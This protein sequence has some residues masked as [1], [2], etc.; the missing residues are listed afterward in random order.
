MNFKNTR[1][2][3]RFKFISFSFCIDISCSCFYFESD[4]KTTT[5]VLKTSVKMG[6]C[7]QQSNEPDIEATISLRSTFE[8][9]IPMKKIYTTL[10][11]AILMV[12]TTKT[13]VS[14]YSFSSQLVTYA[15]ITGGTVFGSSTQDDGAF[16]NP[17]TPGSTGATGPGIPIGFQFWYNYNVFDRI[18]VDNNG[19]IS[20]GQTG[21]TPNPVNANNSLLGR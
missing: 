5:S 4:F 13:Q 14:N 1:G 9:N 3:R 18:G 11:A 6:E 19:W 20:F 2:A 17:A 15:A 12:G 16:C 10:V 21:L 7:R 8:K